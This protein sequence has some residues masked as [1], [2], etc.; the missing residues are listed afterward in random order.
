M[1]RPAAASFNLA[2]HCLGRQAI[3]RGAKP[4][5][6]V[7]DGPEAFH[8]W[9][10]GDLDRMARGL[11]GGLTRNGLK[12]GDRVMISAANG[13]EFI[14]AFFATIAIGCVAQPTSRLL[15][16][17]ETLSLAMDSGAAAIILDKAGDEERKLFSPCLVLDSAQARRL[18]EECEPA[19]YAPTSPDDPA[20][21]VYTSGTT[22]R[23]KGVL[24]AHRVV[25]GR[26]PM[27][28]DWLGLGKDDVVLHAGDV[29]WTYTMGV[30][31]LDP[32]ACGATGAL[33]AGARDPAIWLT[34]IERRR[35]TIFA[36]APG[37]Y[38]QILKY[39]DPSHAD[40]SS[41]RHGVSA[42]EAL[43]P[44]LLA[45]WRE[46]TGT[47][48]Y[49][50]LGMSEVSTYVSSRPGEPIR[51]GSPGR[52]QT[53]RRIAILPVEGGVKPLAPGEVGLLAVHRSDPGLMLGYWNR[54]AEE[55]AAYRGEW[56][57]GGDL[58]AIDADGFV[59]LHGRNDDLMNAS[60]YRVS[61]LEVETA[62][63]THPGISEVAV[64]ERKVAEGVSVIAAFVVTRLV[65]ALDEAAV[66]AHC[67]E[68]LAVYK[69]PRKVVFMSE[70]PRA[71]NG[72]LSRKA[73][74]QLV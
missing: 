64:A 55:A 30:G 23:P 26:R 74:P 7:C 62:L 28:R 48:L 16:L 65:G 61:P 39:G 53:G 6:I 10:Y 44:D 46:A 59:W 40:L 18:A 11:A 49:E 14:L 72:K 56:F 57:I 69:R 66:L 3:E 34:L 54:H 36:A 29:N 9:T 12:K 20:Y 73:L 41:L 32:F 13:V 2:W 42:G 31:V 33:Y 58:A 67:A 52:A 17:E 71:A 37:V 21:L 19:G 15:T 51:P 1:T 50:A 47:W 35:A 4:A 27:H 24:H 60:G 22:A 43:S 5:L 38:R 63:S 45:R 68:R 25:L 8:S 70:L